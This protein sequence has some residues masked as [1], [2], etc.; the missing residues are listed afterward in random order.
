MF[1]DSSPP[2]PPLW[3]H[4]NFFWQLLGDGNLHGSDMSHAMTASL[5]THPSGHLRGTATPW[6]AGEMLD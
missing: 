1:K 4:G 5:Q 6:S 3:V 2:S